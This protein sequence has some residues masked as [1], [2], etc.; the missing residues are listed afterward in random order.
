MSKQKKKSAATEEQEYTVHG[1]A[2]VDVY[3]RVR[4]S[5]EEQARELAQN[6]SMPG[7][8]HQCSGCGAG[9]GDEWG[10]SDGFGDD[11]EI[12]EVSHG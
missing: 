4:A 8:C 1:Y 9:E 3:L 5:S 6:A 12:T 7:L 2:T 11:I 10:L